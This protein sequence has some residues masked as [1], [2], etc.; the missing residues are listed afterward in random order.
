MGMSEKS[1]FRVFQPHWIFLLWTPYTY[2]IYNLWNWKLFFS[3]SRANIS[4]NFSF[5]SISFLSRKWGNSSFLPCSLSFYLSLP[6]PPVL[7]FHLLPRILASPDSAHYPKCTIWSLL[8]QSLP[9]TH[10][11][12]HVNCV[13]FTRSHFLLVFT[14]LHVC[15]FENFLNIFIQF[16][17]TAMHKTWFFRN[18]YFN[19]T[20]NDCEFIQLV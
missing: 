4:L 14:I 11:S 18:V 7:A 13:L 6:P 2:N 20:A 16:N 12:T 10:S 19:F 5:L 1:Q 17:S 9:S 15:Y 3:A 8:P